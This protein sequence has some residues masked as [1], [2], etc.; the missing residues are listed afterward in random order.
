MATKHQLVL[1]TA[2]QARIDFNAS[3]VD[4]FV[5]ASDYPHGRVQFNGPV[6]V[7]VDE[8]VGVVNVPVQ[9]EFGSVGMLRV[10]FTAIDSTAVRSEDYSIQSYSK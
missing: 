7:P 9:R 1:V 3:T 5:R 8:T 2:G 6:Q 10:N 4:I